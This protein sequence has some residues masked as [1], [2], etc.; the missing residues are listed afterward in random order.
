MIQF[1][2][3]QHQLDRDRNQGW[4]LQELPIGLS[5]TSS[6]CQQQGSPCSAP[7]PLSVCF[8][9]FAL[10]RHVAEECSAKRPCTRLP[11]IVARTPKIPM[12]TM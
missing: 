2:I 8:P 10:Y 12:P 6:S 4:I 1:A 9:V 3:Q 11:E 7:F 5:S